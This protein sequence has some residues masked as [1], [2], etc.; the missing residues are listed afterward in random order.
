MQEKTFVGLYDTEDTLIVALEEL[1]KKG[2]QP[3]DMYIIAKRE[4]DVEV[5]RQ[6]TYD[7][8][9][10]VPSNW[11]DRFIGF[12]SGEN[13]VRSMLVEVGFDEAVLRKYEAEIKQGKWLL[14]V[15]GEPKKTVYEIHA[16][17]YSNE[18]NPLK[19]SVTEAERLNRIED[20]SV[21]FGKDGYPKNAYRD[22]VIFEDRAYTMSIPKRMTNRDRADND[23][24]RME[25]GHLGRAGGESLDTRT[26]F[27]SHLRQQLQ[28]I[29]QDHQHLHPF[30]RHDIELQN[31]DS[32]RLNETNDDVMSLHSSASHS[33]IP[34]ETKENT[35]TST[36]QTTTMQHI[37]NK[38]IVIDLRGVNKDKNEVE[39]WLIQDEEDLT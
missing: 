26:P 23:P 37:P 10:S 14:Y 36:T 25:R 3:E 12:I 4:E 30:I 18:K 39:N 32:S 11:L 15:E 13:H 35:T 33:P 29:T 20:D 34:K 9:Q 31:T 6:R 17:R 16:E 28:A 1:R 19:Q 7:E 2:I 5:F 24:I 38:P 27:P 8:I 21:E 22:S